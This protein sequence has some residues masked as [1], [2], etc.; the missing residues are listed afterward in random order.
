MEDQED[1]TTESPELIS[2]L[3]KVWK[4]LNK[5]MEDRG[6]IKNPNSNYNLTEFTNF[7]KSQNGKMNGI[8][9]K[10]DPNNPEARFH[11][12]YEYVPN[13]KIN[14]DTINIFYSQMKEAKVD[15]GIII[16]SGKLSPQAK[17]RID[18]IKTQIQIETFMLGELVVNITEHELV[19]K[20]ILLTNEE[21]T[22]LLKRYRIKE[23]QLPK[24]LVNDPVAKYLGLKRR[25]VVKI[26]RVSETA[27]RYITYRIAC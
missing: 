21:K 7:I 18:E 15:S 26:V 17:Q 8:F 6:Y 11:T 24:I 22:N 23:S 27:G 12:Y 13:A 20:H 5:M 19:P 14:T 2:K 1:L 3:Y 4:T 10:I 9:T 25:D 16:M